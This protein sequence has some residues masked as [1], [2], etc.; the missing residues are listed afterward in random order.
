[1]TRPTP[2]QIE[3]Y[4]FCYLFHF[5]QANAADLMGCTRQN[6]NQLINK[7]KKSNP[8][9]FPPDNPITTIRYH[10]GLDSQIKS[11]F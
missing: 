3:A 9:L 5:K 11:K 8:H 1:M 6:V 2:Q 4:K 7:L 10:I